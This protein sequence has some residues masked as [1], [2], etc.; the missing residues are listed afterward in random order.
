MAT[1][2]LHAAGVMIGRFV[3]NSTVIHAGGVGIATAGVLFMLITF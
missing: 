2:L 1:A 3:R